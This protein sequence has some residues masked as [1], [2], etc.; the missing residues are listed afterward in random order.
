MLSV[1]IAL[2]AVFVV[3]GFYGARF[4]RGNL[5]KLDDWSL[6]GRKLGS[7]LTFFLQGADWYT[8]YSILAIPSAVYLQGYFGFFG[9]AYQTMVF[10]FALIFVP[11]LWARAHEEGYITSSDLVKDRFRSTTLSIFLALL[12]IGA[13]LPYIALQ[14]AGLQAVLS[15]ML[16]GTAS[17]STVGEI[18]LVIAF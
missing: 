3:L 13:V 6:A 14:I 1:F 5:D 17:A 4:R 18:S 7:V 8:A 16:V 15:A 10:A 9:V 12:G 11:V 2:F